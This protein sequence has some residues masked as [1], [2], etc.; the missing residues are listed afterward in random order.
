MYLVIGCGGHAAR[1]VGDTPFKG[2][3]G[4][5]SPAASPPFP[6]EERPLGKGGAGRWRPASEA[7]SQEP[8]HTE[9]LAARTVQGS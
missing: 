5:G 1:S 8:L 4:L 6:T 7:P 9:S 3:G 2:M